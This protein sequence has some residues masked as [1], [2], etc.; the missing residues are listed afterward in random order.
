MGRLL[1]SISLKY[2]EN[3]LIPICLNSRTLRA[4]FDK[5]LLTVQRSAAWFQQIAQWRLDAKF[6]DLNI[7]PP[8]AQ[9]TFQEIESMLKHGADVNAIGEHGSVFERAFLARNQKLLRYLLERGARPEVQS[10]IRGR[11]S[12]EIAIDWRDFELAKLLVEHC[13]RANLLLPCDCVDAFAMACRTSDV[14]MAKMLIDYGMVVNARFPG[15]HTPL[16]VACWEGTAE[17][18]KVLVKAGADVNALFSNKNTPLQHACW[19]RNVEIVKVFVEA[20]ADVNAFFSNG[21]TPLQYAC[22]WQRA[23]IVKVLVEAG[24]NVNADVHPYNGFTALQTAVSWFSRDIMRILLDAGADVTA[25]GSITGGS[26]LKLAAEKCNMDM[27]KLLLHHCYRSKQAASFQAICSKASRY[28]EQYGHSRMSKALRSL[29]EGVFDPELLRSA[30]MDTAFWRQCFP[31]RVDL[32][33]QRAQ[34]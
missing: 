20:G 11:T 15:G 21:L 17:M 34:P 29:A 6:D 8:T 7:T 4:E 16:Q 27:M 30:G 13:A 18:V 24:A 19:R 23:E 12:I 31:P 3:L 22:L 9:S 5:I 25:P 1:K 28:A 2:M 14:T 33:Q 26:A 32:H 10:D